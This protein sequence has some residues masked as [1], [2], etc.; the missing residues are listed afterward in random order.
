MYEW[1]SGYPCISANFLISASMNALWSGWK[2]RDCTTVKR[3]L[4]L[5]FGT[6]AGAVCGAVVGLAAAAGAVVAAGL[7]ASVGLAAAGAE[8]AAGLGASVGFAAGAVVG[9]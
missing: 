4:M 2:S 1:S 9:A 6:A 7:G 3:P 5:T 8:V